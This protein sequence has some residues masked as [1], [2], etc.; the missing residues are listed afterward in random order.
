MS[1]WEYVSHCTHPFE[2]CSVLH[3]IG[4]PK[5][6]KLQ[7]IRVQKCRNPERTLSVKYTTLLSLHMHHNRKADLKAQNTSLF[8]SVPSTCQHC[9]Q[10]N[11]LNP[12]RLPPVNTCKLHP[13]LLHQ[14]TLTIVCFSARFFYASTNSSSSNPFNWANHISNFIVMPAFHGHHW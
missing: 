3:N 5:L 8:P 12:T 14:T 6:G 9:H 10:T 11:A 1:G 13:E 2:K 7:L 4:Q